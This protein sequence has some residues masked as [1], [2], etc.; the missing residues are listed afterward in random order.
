MSDGLKKKI[1]LNKTKSDDRG[2]NDHNEQG[3]GRTKETKF[4][5]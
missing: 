1:R 2:V 3:Q 4:L 5:N